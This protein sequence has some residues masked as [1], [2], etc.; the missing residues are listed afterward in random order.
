MN[1]NHLVGLIVMSILTIL[2]VGCGDDCPDCPPPQAPATSIVLG[3]IQSMDCGFDSG[4]VALYVSGT[5]YGLGPTI[6][7][8]LVQNR[9][10]EL[11]VNG[12]GRSVSFYYSPTSL[13]DLD[14]LSA[15]DSATVRIYALC[16][17]S[18][19]KV[20][21]IGICGDTLSIIGWSTTYSDYDSI[22]TDS[23][24]TIDWHPMAKADWYAI[25]AYYGYDSL[26]YTRYSSLN[27][28]LTDTTFVL[29]SDET[30][31]DGWYDVVVYALTGPTSSSELGNFKGGCTKG[32]M[33]GM[34]SEWI[35]IK[36]GTGGGITPVSSG[37]G[38]SSRIG[39]GRRQKAAQRFDDLLRATSQEPLVKK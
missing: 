7:S 39:S 9:L 20:H 32:I 8:V 27:E 28:V 5:V 34:I 29:A 24:V 11:T 37:Y 4:M 1:R 25:A 22:G 23:L 31:Y 17:V 26:G 19:A 16:G 14:T 38:D 6:D 2:F 30:S 12:L 10:A 15:G 33:N 3:S 18:S 13:S 36:V 35:R 21:T